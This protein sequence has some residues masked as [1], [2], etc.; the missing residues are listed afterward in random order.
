MRF[1]DK[2]VFCL[3]LALGPHGIGHSNQH[4]GYGSYQWLGPNISKRKLAE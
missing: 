3:N 2:L 4:V 1:F